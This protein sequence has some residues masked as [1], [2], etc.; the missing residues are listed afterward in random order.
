MVMRMLANVRVLRK[1]IVVGPKSQ[2]G[3]PENL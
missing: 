1:F 3:D 2:E